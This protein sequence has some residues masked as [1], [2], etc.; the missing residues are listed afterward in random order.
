MNKD[1]QI[2]EVI[3]FANDKKN[4]KAHFISCAKLHRENRC[5]WNGAAPPKFSFIFYFIRTMLWEFFLRVNFKDGGCKEQQTERFK[6]IFRVSTETFTNVLVLF[7][8]IYNA[9]T[10]AKTPISSEE[11]LGIC[12]YRLGSGDYYRSWL[13]KSLSQVWAKS[14]VFENQYIGMLYVVLKKGIEW[15]KI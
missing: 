13:Q 14:R 9:N 15:L 12:L 11:R 8:M 3:Y 10:L 7:A 4:N 6:T 1:I 5:S 2:L